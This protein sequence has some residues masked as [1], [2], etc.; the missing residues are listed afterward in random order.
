MGLKKDERDH[1]SPVSCR[2]IKLPVVRSGILTTL[3]VNF[4]RRL[5]ISLFPGENKEE[6]KE[7]KSKK[8]RSPLP[9]SDT[10]ACACI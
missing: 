1:Q 6:K 7:Q 2:N 10:H 5:G 4:V 8:E 9:F 3:K